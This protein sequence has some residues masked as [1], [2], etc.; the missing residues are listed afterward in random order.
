MSRYLVIGSGSISRRH[1]ANLRLL[2]PKAQVGC[3]SASGRQINST[4]TEATVLFSELA[5]ALLWSPI[6]VVVASPA[7]MHLEHALAFLR[8]EIPV[9]LEKPL[10]DSLITF[11]SYADELL[12]HRHRIGVG[13]NL[14]Y[15]PSAIRMYELIQS[16]VI[17]SLSSISIDLG[18]HLPDWRPKNDYRKSVS[19]NRKLGGGALLELSHEFDYLTWIFG[20]F[21]TVYGLVS[22]S[23]NLDIDVEDRV[24]I[25]FSHSC[26][27]VAYMHLDFLQRKATRRCKVIGS[28]GNIVWDLI[29]NSISIESSDKTEVIMS[30]PSYNRNQMYLDQLLHFEALAK[31]KARPLVTLESAVY[32]I[33]LIEAARES[34]IT[35]HSISLKEINE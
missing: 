1:I 8:R 14:R 12:T 3:V 34:A 19:A 22:N 5:D 13:Y 28:K 4:E 7:P 31:G 24:D 18:Q 15:L 32:T 17:G 10:T 35:K 6:F 33:K 2:F 9:L 21:D 23:G 30:E 25:L 26:G 11:E 29:A 20:K 16:D 27:L